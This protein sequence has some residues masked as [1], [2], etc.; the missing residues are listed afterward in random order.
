MASNNSYSPLVN[1]LVPQTG[2]TH[3]YTASIVAS[4]T[5]QTLD[6]TQI[7]QAYQT[8]FVP[9]GVYVDAS[10]STADVVLV[11]RPLGLSI[12][13]QAGT[14]QAFSYP[15]PRHNQKVDVTGSGQ[16]VLSFVDYPVFPSTLYSPATLTQSVSVKNTPLPVSVPADVGGA[17]YNVS[18]QAPV[19][20]GTWW[21]SPTTAGTTYT[22]PIP[23]GATSVHTQTTSAAFTWFSFSAITSQP[24]HDSVT[25]GPVGVIGPYIK[26]E[27]SI[28]TG[29]ANLYCY[30]NATSGVI[31]TNFFA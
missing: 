2:G 9:Q 17:A 6:W 5:P 15:A 19:I 31:Q 28:P 24:A 25:T 27:M 26:S 3:T 7:S 29:M 20:L 4:N 16:V 12:R 1:L 8:P 30:T 13:C 22:I 11:I 23:V 14:I 21:T 10:Q 18:P